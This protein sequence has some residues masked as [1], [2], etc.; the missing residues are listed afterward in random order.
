M[1]THQD[2]LAFQVAL[3]EALNAHYPIDH[4][5]NEILSRLKADPQLASFE[6]YLNTFEDRMVEV[7]AELV[8]KWGQRLEASEN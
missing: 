4:P 1:E 5:T 6:V 8:K 7:A 3:L 2:L